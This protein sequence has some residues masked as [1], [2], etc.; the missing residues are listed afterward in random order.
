MKRQELM[1]LPSQMLD[2][3]N[4]SESL[5]VVGGTSDKG[6]TEPANN[7]SGRCVGTNNSDGT[8]TGTNNGSGLCNGINNSGGKC[9]FIENN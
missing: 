4:E 5:L 6:E 8:C 2:A 3:L 1:R 7:G 9:G